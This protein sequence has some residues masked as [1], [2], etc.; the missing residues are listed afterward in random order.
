MKHLTLYL[1]VALAMSVSAT[2]GSAQQSSGT[3]VDDAVLG[4][5]PVGEW[6]SYGLDYAETRYR[7]LDQISAENVD[8]LGL[9]WTHDLVSG[10]GRIEATPL[11]SDGVMYASGAWSSMFAL[12]AETGEIKWHWDPA[13]VRGGREAGGPTVSNGA[14][15]RGVAL[16]D[17]KIYVGLLDG[18]LVALDAETGRPVWSVQTT[19][20]GG[21]SEYIITGAPRVV[22]GKVIIWN[23]GAEY[24]GVRGYVTAYD[25]E[26]GEQAWRFY[27]VPGNPSL[28]FESPA[29]EMAATT[30]A[31]EWWK[32]GGGGTA[33]DNFSYDLEADLLYVGT[34]NGAPWSYEYRSQSTGD[35]LFL[36]CILA[37]NPDTGALVWYYQT[38]PGDTWDYT[39]T[40]TMTLVDVVIDGQ[41]RKVLTQAPKNGFFYVLDRITDELISAEPITEYINWASGIDMETGRPIV[42]PEA[43]FDE[44]G[45]WVSPSQGGAHNWN[46]MSYHP[47]TGLIYLAGRNTQS[48]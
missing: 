32:G 24:W 35:N 39:S 44:E 48:F 34:G 8:G 23:S 6:L 42:N 21:Y 30:W 16:Y 3:V 25:A 43:R 40:M 1:P 5:P 10:D 46:P 41:E 4:A 31:G 2:A 33:W 14:P 19:P 9:A 20:Y 47:N 18:R 22:K 26:T 15:N 11:V 45:A 27:T 37:L 28:G 36:N 38:V 7:P 17:G 13:I 29:M 12:D